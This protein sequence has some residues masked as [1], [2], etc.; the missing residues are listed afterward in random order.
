MVWWTQLPQTVVDCIVIE[1]TIP[2][3]LYIE[4]NLPI[5]VNDWR[6]LAS[7]LYDRQVHIKRLGLSGL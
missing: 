2:S 1:L 7:H 3:V 5:L 6:L 4:K